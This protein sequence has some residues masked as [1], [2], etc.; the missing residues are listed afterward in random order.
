MEID[1]FRKSRYYLLAVYSWALC[2]GQQNYYCIY[3]ERIPELGDAVNIHTIESHDEVFLNVLDEYKN[4]QDLDEF[5]QRFG[6]VRVRCQKITL[7]NK[8]GD[9]AV[10]KKKTVMFRWKWKWPTI[11]YVQIPEITDSFKEDDPTTTF[12]CGIGD[13]EKRRNFCLYMKI[14]Y[15]Y[16]YNELDWEITTL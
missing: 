7:F 10:E 11:S 13:S 12:L 16:E 3:V 5:L 15:I 6:N 1:I 2:W 14:P 9:F 4:K 8:H